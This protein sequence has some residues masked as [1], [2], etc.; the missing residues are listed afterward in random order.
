M[1]ARAQ[2]RR[3]MEIDLR[4]ALSRGEFELHYQPIYDL[5][6]EEIVCFEALLRW[7]H[8][9]DGMLLPAT[10][11][12]LAE[13]TGLIVPIGAWVLR[14]ACM[15]AAR[16]VTKGEGRRQ[17]FAGAVQ[18]PEPLTTVIS[19]LSESHLAANRLELEITETVLLQDN[20]VRSPSCTSFAISASESRWTTSVPAIRSLSYLRSF[21]FDKIKIDSSFVRE[22]AAHGDSMAIVRAVTGLGTSMG[23]ST[24]AEGSRRENSSRCCARRAARRCKDISSARRDRLEISR[25]CYP[26]FAP[27]WSR[28]RKGAAAKGGWIARAQGDLKHLRNSL[29]A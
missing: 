29:G 8:P 5:A 26:V 10:F 18:K 6:T 24:T 19:A 2:A 17:S 13:E 28:R 14:Q 21:P 7:H 20:R 11:I 1:D 9:R 12:P 23:I 4:A 16:L 22:L 3:S 15:E 27:A 25:P